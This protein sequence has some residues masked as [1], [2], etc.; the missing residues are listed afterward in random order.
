MKHLLGLFAADTDWASGNSDH[1]VAVAEHDFMADSE[2]EVS[3]RRGQKIN[4]APKGCC[5]VFHTSELLCLE[6]L[7]V[8]LHN[9][10]NKWVLGC[11]FLLMILIQ[12]LRNARFSIFAPLFS[13]LQPRVR[14]WLLATVDGKKEGLIPANYVKILG[15]RKGC[16]VVGKEQDSV[17][18][19]V[20][21][22]RIPTLPG[23][24]PPPSTASLHPTGQI[25]EDAWKSQASTTEAVTRK[26]SELQSDWSVDSTKSSGQGPSVLDSFGFSSGFGG[27]NALNPADNVMD[28]T[29]SDILDESMKDAAN[30]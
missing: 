1:F 24:P 12:S 25:Q 29:A 13:E 30:T 19:S 4:V 27:P 3:F 16:G 7:P 5:C 18:G 6:L 8:Y 23:A 20:P 14:G 11:Y 17:S 26:S 21:S 22:V 15:K 28:R 10:R 9:I 2:E